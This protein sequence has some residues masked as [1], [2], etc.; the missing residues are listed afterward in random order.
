MSHND[1]S[2][3]TLHID[4]KVKF[5]LKIISNAFLSPVKGLL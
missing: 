1:K 5:H 4:Y 3:T 2:D